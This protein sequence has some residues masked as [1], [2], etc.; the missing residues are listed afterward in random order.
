MAKSKSRDR[1]REARWRRIIREHG[2]SGLGVREFCRRGKLR[3]TAFY[4]WRRE[5]LRRDGQRQEAEHVS[6][7][8]LEKPQEQR[9]QPARRARRQVGGVPAFVPVRVEEQHADMGS[10]ASHSRGRIE[11]EL[12]GGRLVH[13]AAPVDRQ[14]LADVLA[15]LEGRP[16]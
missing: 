12:S 2:R 4:F 16:C 6:G 9:R 1:Q 10:A 3:E 15:V 13:V 7:V 14:A 11:I 5:L 8:A